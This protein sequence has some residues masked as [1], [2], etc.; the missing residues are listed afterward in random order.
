MIINLYRQTHTKP[1][2]YKLENNPKI[3]IFDTAKYPDI[4]TETLTFPLALESDGR[5]VHQ[6]IK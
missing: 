2:S 1:I 6:K 5:G 3:D 4:E